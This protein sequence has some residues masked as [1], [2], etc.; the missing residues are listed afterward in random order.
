MLDGN[1]AERSS[2]RAAFLAGEVRNPTLD[3][4][5]ID[6]EALHKKI[7]VLERRLCEAVVMDDLVAR[8]AT[9]DTLN[10]R[11]AE[12]YWLLEASRLNRLHANSDQVELERVLMRYKM[13]NEA[14]YGAPDAETTDQVY[15]EIWAQIESKE[16]DEVGRRLLMELQ[17]GAVIDAAQEAVSIPPLSRPDSARRLPENV[18]EAIVPLREFL[19]EEFA[20]FRQIIDEYYA[21]V[22]MARNESDKH[23]GQFSVPDMQAVFEQVHLLRDPQ[24]YA[25]ISIRVSEDASQLAWDTPSMSVVIGGQRAAIDSTQEMLAKVVHEYGVQGVRAVNGKKTEL[26]I[27]G[28]GL[29]TEAQEGELSDYLTFEEGFASICE[30]AILDEHTDWGAIY[31]SRYIAASASHDGLDF[32]QAFEQNWRVRTLMDAKSGE[33]ITEKQIEKSKSQA[34]ISVTRIRRGG[35][36]SYQGDTMPAFNKD[37]AYLKGKLIALAYLRSI[38]N[39][40]AL[41]RRL[42]AGKFDPTNAIQDRLVDTYALH[43]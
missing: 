10:Y 29:F 17:I 16:L 1:R 20:D 34:Y 27:L 41:L 11:M 3:Y 19:L 12:M 22:C 18:R 6:E 37:I 8:E 36:T 33:P 14:L 2:Q 24:N 7:R 32:R 13:A 5:F 4:P 30:M 40:R 35:P 25:D 43:Q 38:G 26:P 21:T 39:D 28:A 9:C 23:Y 42:F 15:G 31:V